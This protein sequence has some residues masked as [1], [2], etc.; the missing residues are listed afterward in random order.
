M[1]RPAHSQQSVE[2][3]RARNQ[4]IANRATI[5]GARW[6]EFTVLLR[7]LGDRVAAVNDACGPGSLREN[8][9]DPD[10]FV[11]RRFSLQSAIIRSLRASAALVIRRFATTW[12]ACWLYLT[13]QSIIPFFGSP[14]A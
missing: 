14:P 6:P 4:Q 11:L 10:V 1:Y 7:T 8:L 13:L 3:R 12:T 9:Q 2:A 5:L